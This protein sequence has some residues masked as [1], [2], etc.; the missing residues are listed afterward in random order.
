MHK[1]SVLAAAIA[2]AGLVGGLMA[3]AGAATRDAATAAPAAPAAKKP[4]VCKGIKGCYVMGRIDVTGDKRKDWVGAVN[5]NGRSFK[6][7]K[8]TVRVLSKGRIDKTT[9]TVRRW[10]GDVFHGI[11]R[12]DGRRGAEMVVGAKRKRYTQRSPMDEHPTHTFAKSFYV[13]GFRHGSL[14]A[15]PAPGQKTKKWNLTSRDGIVWGNTSTPDGS[16]SHTRGYVRKLHKGKLTMT[17]KDSRCTGL[18]GCRAER[19]TFVWRKGHWAKKSAKNADLGL[20][21]GWQV[22]G[23]PVW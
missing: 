9:L 18:A 3:D 23:L 15:L 7:G 5:R 1:W 19:V 2:A 20:H 6:K 12:I 22:K 21:G 11:A 13:L 8:V 17:R 10:K 16:G 14:R 4:G